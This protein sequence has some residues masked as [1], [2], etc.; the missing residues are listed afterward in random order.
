MPERR[1]EHVFDDAQPAF[2]GEN[3]PVRGERAMRDVGSR[4]VER[5]QCRRQLAKQPRDE[6]RVQRL[7][8]PL[9][10]QLRQ[11]L[12]RRV[13]RH[14]RQPIAVIEMLERADRR[15]HRVLE[16]L[17]VP[18]AIAKY[19]LESGR[20][21]EIGA[22]PQQLER[23]RVGVVEH[24]QPIA[25]AIGPPGDV[26]AGE[27]VA[28]LAAIGMFVADTVHRRLLDEGRALRLTRGERA[29]GQLLWTVG[30]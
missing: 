11:T 2:G 23:R 8:R 17:Q 4:R 21:R 18:D 1:T 13:H 20:R 14:E 12:S 10:E 28:G 27:T 9:C 22:K 19:F 16:V 3:D 25:E 30:G 26:P 15:E 6:A 5:G 29:S 7:A 24:E